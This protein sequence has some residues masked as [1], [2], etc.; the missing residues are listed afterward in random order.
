Y[1]ERVCLPS[2]DVP[3]NLIPRKP[4][5]EGPPPITLPERFIFIPFQDDRDTQVR[6]HSPWVRNMRDLFALGE[7]IAD[8]TGWEVVFK[9][10]PSSR[11]SY[12]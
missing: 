12:P 2:D 11:E 3:V 5:G 4:R 9:E 7:R 10:H 6:L 1:A 8:E